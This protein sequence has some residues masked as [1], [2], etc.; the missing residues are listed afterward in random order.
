M[1]E[2][3]RT[4]MASPQLSLRDLLGKPYTDA[5]CEA[6]AFVEGGDRRALAAIAEEKVDFAPEWYRRRIDDL[7]D[8][9]GEQICSG[10][11]HSAQGAGTT[12][13]KNAMKVEAAPLT[14]LG[15]IRVG[16]DGRAY[17]VSKSEHYHAS[18]G[19]SFPGYRLIENAKRLGI[20]NATHNNT[21][22]HV[23]RVL[24]QELVRT[25]NAIPRDAEKRLRQV[26]DSSE[27]HV[28]NRV[29]NLETGSLAVEAALK[30]MLARFYKVQETFDEPPYQGRIPVFLVIADNAGGKK[31]NYHGTTM[32]TQ[33]MR[34]M[35]P[36]F[37]TALEDND[38]LIVKPVRINDIGDF[39]R[40]LTA[41]DSEPYKVAGFFH[42]IILMNYGGI[43]LT[44]EF[45][46]R[47]YELCHERDVPT[48]VD[49]IQSCMWSPELFL[50]QEYG[51]QPDLVSLGKGFPGGEYPASRIITTA[52][53]DN[54]NQFGALVTNG[55]EELASIAY[56][57]TMAFAQANSAYTRE[58]G[59]YYESELGSLARGFPTAIAKIE[60][61][62]HLSTIV[63]NS[64]DATVKFIAQ[65]NDAGIDI[66]AHTYK[67]DCPP[68]A[69]TKIPL[70]ST[71]KMVD[72]LISKMHKALKH[73]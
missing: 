18:L 70:I 69:L 35:W 34:G 44:E 27:P 32:L 11:P 62:R 64:I 71:Y 73:L 5:V 23:T 2:N 24:E 37:G 58:I 52:A 20:P 63:F 65:L 3:K 36:Q 38:A 55:Q 10:L 8:H 31:A 25:A 16:E 45:L 42:E 54:L 48:M 7:V 39:E 6:R 33:V 68:V 59:G 49:E 41:Y 28:L 72:F 47:A 53:L 19:H 29:I 14:G 15:F 21:R 30:M 50:F 17:L 43:R 67:A 46:K 51:L 12:S 40:A 22:G 13:F 66:S 60:G 57:V 56:L 1:S 9:V 26:I 4:S 61:S